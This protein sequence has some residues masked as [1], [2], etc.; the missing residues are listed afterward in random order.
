MKEEIELQIFEDLEYLFEKWP[1]FDL[2]N[3]SIKRASSVLNRLF[4][5][6]A[7]LKVW[8]DNFG[9]QQII[10]PA[11]YIK[12]LRYNEINI[13]DE[14]AVSRTNPSNHVGY[15]SVSYG[16]L[17]NLPKFKVIHEEALTL[18]KYFS[19]PSLISGGKI[20]SRE[21]IIR[22]IE[23]T[24]SGF[25]YDYDTK[26]LLGATDLEIFGTQVGNSPLP[27]KL[28]LDYGFELANSQSIQNLYK[29][30]AKKYA[31]IEPPLSV[32]NL[33]VKTEGEEE[34]MIEVFKQD[35]WN[36]YVELKSLLNLN[37]QQDFEKH[38][39]LIHD[40][41]SL[42]MEYV[43]GRNYQ[44][45]V[46]LILQLK[47]LVEDIQIVKL[48]DEIKFNIFRNENL[49]HKEDNA[50]Y[51]F[52]F[53]LNIWASLIKKGVSVIK[54]ERPDFEINDLKVYIEA[55]SCRKRGD[56]KYVDFPLKI[57]SVINKKLENRGEYMNLST[58]LAIDITNLY[59]EDSKANFET[60]N[61]SEIVDEIK[62]YILNKEVGCILLFTYYLVKYPMGYQ[63]SYIRIDNKS[64]DNNLVKFLDDNF[65]MGEFQIIDVGIPYENV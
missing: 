51:G 60:N 36:I 54:S 35:F 47:Q 64:I 3:A 56:K 63:S 7:L 15:F 32:L 48:N 20:Y 46:L 2:N 14:T 21:E 13:N 18:K 41:L 22:K 34:K 65:P 28:I 23:Y 53:E 49:K 1:I 31:L 29:I 42:V 40:E 9:K 58:V 39:P 5:Y 16:D 17:D 50:Y 33:G 43:D 26:G 24:I 25:K 8:I 45:A 12:V 30:L 57:K 62:E 38:V 52:R 6:R 59:H 44:L 55:T 27:I 37:N 19:M 4:D 11:G 10:I 61:Y